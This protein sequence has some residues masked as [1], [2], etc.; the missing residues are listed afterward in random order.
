M[1]F[2]KISILCVGILLTSCGK[3][4]DSGSSSAD[5]TTSSAVATLSGG[6]LAAIQFVPASGNATSTPKSIQVFFSETS[7][8]FN[9]DLN[10]VLS[11]VNY[12]YNCNGQILNPSSVQYA[13]SYTYHSYAAT[14]DFSNMPSAPV[15]STCVLNL[16]SNIK[17]YAG[18][19]L[20]GLTSLT[21]NIVQSNQLYI[22]SI[23]VT[24]YGPLSSGTMTALPPSLDINFS[25]SNL[26]ISG[27]GNAVNSISNYSINCGGAVYSPTNI[28][29]SGG[30]KV[31]VYMPSSSGLSDGTQCIFSVSS[32][33][34]DSVGN[35]ITGNLSANYVI[36]AQS[37]YTP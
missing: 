30:N 35:S 1:R 33:L 10:S 15:G 3:K 34:H 13:Y 9:Y 17:D 32:G 5:S 24:N 20:G 19:S 37:N 27:G 6:P 26:D 7:L 12:Q 8:D 29:Y 18:N 23:A 28:A 16:S 14:L 4:G 22:Q 36:D 2:L 31:T 21:Y 25:K 11:P